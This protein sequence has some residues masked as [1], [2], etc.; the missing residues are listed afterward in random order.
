[1][2]CQLGNKNNNKNNIT[3]IIVITKTIII[4]I[5][6]KTIRNR[7][8]QNLNEKNTLVLLFPSNWNS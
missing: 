3:I 5:I 6:T 1:M 7:K 4:I 2:Y 8:M